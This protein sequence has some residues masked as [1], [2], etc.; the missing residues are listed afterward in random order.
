MVWCIGSGTL[1]IV[2]QS[3]GGTQGVCHQDVTLCKVPW[4]PFAQQQPT[5]IRSD[6]SPDVQ[7]AA[8]PQLPDLLI[9]WQPQLSSEPM[10]EFLACDGLLCVAERARGHLVASPLP[11]GSDCSLKA[12]AYLQNCSRLMPSMPRSPNPVS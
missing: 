1:G 3:L 5:P 7:S 9:G 4:Q 2:R 8:N 12:Q 11:F 10:S 6:V